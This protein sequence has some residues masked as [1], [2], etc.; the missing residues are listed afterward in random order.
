MGKNN[1]SDIK[2]KRI[3]EKTVSLI[4]FAA[5]CV[6]LLLGHLFFFFNY[7]LPYND[8][9]QFYLPRFLHSY[10]IIISPIV[11]VFLWLFGFYLSGHYTVPARKSGL[12]IFGPT[13]TTSFI[14]SILFFFTLVNYT[15]IN[16]QQDYISL[17]IR[18]FLIFFV[19]VFSFRM[20]IISR[21]QQLIRKGKVA[22]LSILVGNNDKALEIVEDYITNKNHYGHRIIGYVKDVKNG[23]DFTNDL[24]LLGDLSELEKIMQNLSVD[25]AIVSLPH[26]HHIDVN[27]AINILRQKDILIKLSSDINDMIEGSVRNQNLESLPYI[28]IGNNKMPVWQSV[29]KRSFDFTLALLALL[30]SSPFSLIIALGVKLSSKGPI[31]FKQERIGKHKKPFT[32]YKFRSMYVDAEKEGPSLSSENDPRITPFGRFLR[33]WRFDELPQFINVIMGDMSFVGP[34]PERKYFIDQII[35]TAPHY[36]LLFSVRPGITSWG[37]VKYGYAENISQMIDRLQYDILYLENRTLVIDFKIM[38]Y[39]LRTIISGEGK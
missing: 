6:A 23:H 21:L 15:P 33:K 34:R 5:D 18:Y 39:T 2:I 24:P 28:I 10:A 31:F 20:L 36:A 27:K 9:F 14:I 26:S 3:N 1:N 35:P 22:Y 16:L 37:M 11:I 19:V 32:I 13:I 12:Q 7:Q 8:I 30:I 17:F 4:H 29:F 38:L 25:E